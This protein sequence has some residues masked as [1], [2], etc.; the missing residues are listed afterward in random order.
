VDDLPAWINAHGT[1]LR[2]VPP[3]TRPLACGDVGV[4]A[5]APLDAILAV[6]QSRLGVFGEDSD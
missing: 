5:L 2:V 4:G 3:D 1:R 6:V